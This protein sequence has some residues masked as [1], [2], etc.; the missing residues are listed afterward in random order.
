MADEITIRDADRAPVSVLTDAVVQR[1]GSPAAGA[2][3]GQVVKLAHGADGVFD[4]VSTLSPM[5][6]ADFTPPLVQLARNGVDIIAGEITPVVA[7]NALRELVDV[8]CDQDDNVTPRARVWLSVGTDDPAVGKGNFLRPDG[9][10]SQWTADAVTV[11]SDTDCRITWV[12][13]GR[14]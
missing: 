6:A 13:W 10:F 5:P 14:P 2:V 8:M 7:P 4:D 12:E 1:N 11:L 9:S 3:E